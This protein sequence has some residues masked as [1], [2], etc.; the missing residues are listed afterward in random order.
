MLNDNFFSQNFSEEPIEYSEEL[1]FFYDKLTDNF[2]ILELETGDKTSAYGN[3]MSVECLLSELKE[4]DNGYKIEK[5]FF[6][7]NFQAE[8]IRLCVIRKLDNEG[9]EQMLNV[10][11]MDE[12]DNTE[13]GENR[14][15]E[16][17]MEDMEPYGELIFFKKDGSEVIIETND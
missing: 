6:I 7:I 3:V 13:A 16:E 5:K 1:E 2:H 4:L 15:Y 11:F 10:F 17:L 8:P 9:E 14:H 12:W